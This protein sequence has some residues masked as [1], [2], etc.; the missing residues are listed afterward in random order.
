MQNMTLG[1]NEMIGS[2]FL[3]NPANFGV[4]NIKRRPKS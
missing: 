2:H 1:G 4:Y 3:I